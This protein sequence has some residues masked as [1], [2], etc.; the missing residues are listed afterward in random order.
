[1]Q[2]AVFHSHDLALTN[3]SVT[4]AHVANG[5]CNRHCLNCLYHPAGSAA[6]AY[7]CQ[8]KGESVILGT[9]KLHCVPWTSR[10]SSVQLANQIIL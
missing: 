7:T 10:S 3:Y 5:I 4:F 2:P 6:T 1:M 8:Y 9:K